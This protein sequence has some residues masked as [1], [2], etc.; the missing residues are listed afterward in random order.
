VRA[1]AGH[2]SQL[3]SKVYRSL[4]KE[5]QVYALFR[6]LKSIAVYALKEGKSEEEVLILLRQRVGKASAPVTSAVVRAKKILVVRTTP[7]FTKKLFSVRPVPVRVTRT[8]AAGR[9]GRVLG[10]KEAT[11][12]RLKC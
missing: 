12:G 11:V 3:A 5:E 8:R 9:R 1:E 6:E 7:C 2:V 4:H 10:Q